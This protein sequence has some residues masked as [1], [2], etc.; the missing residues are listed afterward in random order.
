MCPRRSR[1][2]RCPHVGP[3]DLRFELGRALAASG[4]SRE[5]LSRFTGVID[6]GGQRVKSPRAY[7]RSFFHR[8]Q[9]LLGTDRPEEARADLRRYLA[10]FADGELARAEV[11][12]AR[13]LLLPASA[14]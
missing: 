10:F 8:G 7:V 12:A 2:H 11:D 13:A 1:V 9:V 6:S 14:P 4:R 5:A 3:T